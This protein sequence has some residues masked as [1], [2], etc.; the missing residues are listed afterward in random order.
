[1]QMYGEHTSICQAAAEPALEHLV[2]FACLI[3]SEPQIYHSYQ[4]Y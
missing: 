1:M 3:P 2:I 4:V